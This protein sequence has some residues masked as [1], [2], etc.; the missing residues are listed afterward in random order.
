MHWLVDAW[1]LAEAKAERT[2]TP[3]ITSRNI[4]TI[5]NNFN[6]ISISGYNSS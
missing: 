1:N 2:N 6:T 3:T 4:L 5:I